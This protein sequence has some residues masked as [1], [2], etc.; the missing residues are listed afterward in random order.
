MSWAMASEEKTILLF[1][2]ARMVS[3]RSLGSVLFAR[4]LA[5]PILI[6]S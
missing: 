6:I 1:M 5:A 2:V 4:Y 3:A